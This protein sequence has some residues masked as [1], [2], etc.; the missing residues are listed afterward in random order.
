[1]CESDRVKELQVKPCN[2]DER[3]LNLRL[4]SA[5]PTLQLNR[6]TSCPPSER[7]TCVPLTLIQTDSLLFFLHQLATAWQE[8]WVGWGGGGG[9]ERGKGGGKAQVL[10]PITLKKTVRLFLADKKKNRTR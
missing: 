4:S 6:W 10:N 3:K 7:L 1:M 9:G 8:G 2:G 5:Q